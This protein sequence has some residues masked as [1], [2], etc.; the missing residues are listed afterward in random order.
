MLIGWRVGVLVG[1]TVGLA[2]VMGR[3]VLLGV[4]VIVLVWVALGITIVAAG[5]A[6]TVLVGG[7]TF[8]GRQPVKMINRNSPNAIPANSLNLFLFLPVNSFMVD[9]SSSGTL[10]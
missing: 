9:G 10:L 5:T 6:M 8:A 1:V 2:V 4:D 7:S 3:G